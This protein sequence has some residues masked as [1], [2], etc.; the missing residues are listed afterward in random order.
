MRKGLCQPQ[1]RISLLTLTATAAGDLSTSAFT[2]DLFRHGNFVA[3]PSSHG[4]LQHREE[5]LHDLPGHADL[6]PAP[7]PGDRR[8]LGKKTY[9]DVA[10]AVSYPASDQ[11]SQDL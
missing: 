4:Q 6:G 7:G 5:R 11:Q 1:L 2:W 3:L 9:S 10:V 8:I